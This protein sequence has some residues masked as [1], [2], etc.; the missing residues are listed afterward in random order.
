[1]TKFPQIDLANARGPQV[2]IETSMGTIQLQLFP[3]QAPKTVENFVTHAQAGYYDGLTF[4]RVIPNFM[5]QGGD[6]TGTGMGGESI[7]GQ[8]FED[9]FS[10][11]LYNLRGA[12]SMANAG[13]NTNGSQFFIVQDKDMTEQMQ[14]Q[15]KDAGFPDEIVDAY[16][17]GGTPWLDFRHTVFGQVISGMDVVDAIAQVKT[18]ASDQPSTPVTMDK[19]TIQEND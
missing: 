3:E 2:T 10:Q 13:P 9:E 17:N 19:V 4:H 5:I 7:W 16:K 14:G 11:E 8:P 12:V 1:M 6:P 18:D 15:M